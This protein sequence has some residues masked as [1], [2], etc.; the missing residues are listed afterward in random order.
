ML[1]LKLTG[2]GQNVL[3]L[4]YELYSTG[5][6]QGTAPEIAERTGIPVHRVRAVCQVRRPTGGYHMI[7]AYI[8]HT[9]W[10]ALIEELYGQRH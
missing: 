1:M 4:G 6:R 7:P 5:T 2:A 10:D 3:R 8:D 9:E